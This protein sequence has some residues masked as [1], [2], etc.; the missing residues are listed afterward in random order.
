VGEVDSVRKR[1]KG[2]KG[3]VFSQ[4]TKLKDEIQVEVRIQ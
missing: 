1:K 2:P 3:Q 4:G